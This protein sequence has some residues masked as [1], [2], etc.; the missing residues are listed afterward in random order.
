LNIWDTILSGAVIAALIG[1]VEV[2]LRR[3]WDKQDKKD[4]VSAKLDRLEQM[5]AA[6]IADDEQYKAETKRARILQFNKE[7]RER[8]RHSEEEFVE[9]L[10]V[11]DEYE[12]YCRNHPEYPN[13]RAVT[14]I[15]NIKYVYKNANQ[16]ND[17][18]K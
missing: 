14:A 7:V 17:F 5:L 9:I 12:D 18:V 8:E 1:L 16:E 3:M 6:H 4:G 2:L 10:K 13:N 15:E 11:I